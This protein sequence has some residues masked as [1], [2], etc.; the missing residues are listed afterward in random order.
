MKRV[1]IGRVLLV[2]LGLTGPAAA[3]TLE[4]ILEDKHLI[5]ANE[6]KAA[7]EKEQAAT[8][9]AIAAIPPLPEW[10]KMVTLF[11]DARVRNETFFQEGT[12][13]RVHQR[14]QLRFG[15]KVNPNDEM[16]SGFKLA[17]GNSNDPISNNQTFT[18]EF[19]PKSINISNAYVKLMPSHSIALDRP[20]VTVMGG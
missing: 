16:E 8:E 14:F 6:A 10:L 5:D 17:S 13:D 1:G 12:E 15:A 3:R 20:W 7:R 2:L 18:D 11:A 4:E 19:T 9:K